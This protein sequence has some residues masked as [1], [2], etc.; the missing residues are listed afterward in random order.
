M[1]HNAA[2]GTALATS[3]RMRHLTTLTMILGLMSGCVVGADGDISDV[4]GGDILVLE[5]PDM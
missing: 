2:R 3:P 4:E 1:L 5:Q